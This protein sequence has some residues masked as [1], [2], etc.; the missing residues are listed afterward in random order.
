MPL[1]S[2]GRHQRPDMRRRAGAERR[3]VVAALQR[4]DNPAAG[5]PAGGFEKLLGYP[6]V[7]RFVE[8]KLRQRVA[9]VGVEPGRDQQQ[10]GTER[11]ERRAGCRASARAGTRAS[12]TSARSGTLTILS[13]APVSPRPPV[14][15]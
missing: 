6:D 13:A 10:L 8:Q 3:Q 9:P 7:I 15:G 1:G 2:A 11:V 5:V 14:P 4:R 12:R